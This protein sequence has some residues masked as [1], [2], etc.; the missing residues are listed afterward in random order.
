LKSIQPVCIQ[1]VRLLAECLSCRELIALP[2]L[3]LLTNAVFAALM[4][5]FLLSLF[6][7]SN[8][9]RRRSLMFVLVVLSVVL[10]LVQYA[11]EMSLRVRPPLL[12]PSR[13]LTLPLL[14]MDG[15]NHPQEA[16][17]ALTPTILTSILILRD[18]PNVVVDLALFARLFVVYPPSTTSRHT[19]AV[20]LAPAVLIK[21]ARV[22]SMAVIYVYDDQ[23][24]QGAG[25]YIYWSPWEHAWLIANRVLAV[26]DNT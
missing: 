17:T 23:N 12:L 26:L 4:V 22:A 2:D 24:K 8:A 16:S 11:Y 19:L 9:H 1:R 3:D 13:A 7:F 14:Q 20:V 18:L 10:A 15:L 21:I 25:L 5:P 6:F